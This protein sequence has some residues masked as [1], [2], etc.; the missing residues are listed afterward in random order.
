MLLLAPAQTVDVVLF[1]SF[2]HQLHC[3]QCP[4]EVGEG[5]AHR[6]GITKRNSMFK[7]RY[8]SCPTVA[9]IQGDSISL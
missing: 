8:V 2:L 4:Q 6:I 1:L 7:H 3:A 9:Y 5:A